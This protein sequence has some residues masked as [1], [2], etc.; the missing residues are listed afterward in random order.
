M[1]SVTRQRT[2]LL[3]IGLVAVAF[4]SGQYTGRLASR[5]ESVSTE[6]FA[7]ALESR[8]WVYRAHTI[9]GYV[10]G[11]EP[12][13]LPAAL[14]AVEARRRW[15]SQDELRLFMGAWASFDPE[16]AF[17]RSL[18]WPDH[19]RN[20]G[21]AAA[22]YGWALRDPQAAHR[23][24]M[25]VNDSNL[26]ALLLDRLVAAW[27]HGEDRE[28][29]TL[30]IAG[31]PNEPS[32]SRLTSILVREILADGH[33]AV[34]AWAE[35]IPEEDE[36]AF[37][38]TA[39]R[40]AAGILA[41]DDHAA[42]VEFVERNR[43]A[44]GVEGAFAAVARRWV[45]SD[46]EAALG[47]TRRLPAGAGRDRA[48][49]IGFAHWQ[50]KNPTAAERWL[51]AAQESPEL[52]PARFIVVRELAATAPLEALGLAQAIH[53]PATKERGLIA[54]LTQ[55]LQI[56]PAAA[57]SWLAENSI[58]DAARKAVQSRRKPGRRRA[59]DGEVSPGTEPSAAESDENLSGAPKLR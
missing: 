45:S 15:L 9:S 57:S 17:A 54:V 36:T 46:P 24:A 52:D 55:W 38:S 59:G 25:T 20:K 35:A 8:D 33:G 21:A 3:S 10:D 27:A 19:T 12:E 44:P 32:R 2:L 49:Q 4:A 26:K 6:Q 30:Y 51:L 16:A 18:T 5:A 29:A 58:S 37:R 34:M 39:F 43:D 53:D 23:A 11:L 7:Q 1:Q 50:K 47:W 41:Q 48:V 22:I 40:K 28:G 31:L 56:D 13:N 14:A 42:A